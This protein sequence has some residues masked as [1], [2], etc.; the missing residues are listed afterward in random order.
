MSELPWV[1]DGR[2]RGGG[3]KSKSRSSSIEMTI[4]RQ[5]VRRAVELLDVEDIQNARAQ[6]ELAL[7]AMGDE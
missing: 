4:A 1:K 7:R 3:S 2:F 6:L 5:S